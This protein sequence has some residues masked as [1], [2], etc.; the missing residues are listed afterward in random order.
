MKLKID[1]LHLYAVAF[2]NADIN[3]SWLKDI[4]A[5]Y[6]LKTGDIAETVVFDSPAKMVDIINRIINGIAGF[7]NKA[8]ELTD[9]VKQSAH[10]QP[11]DDAPLVVSES[12][13]EG[14]RVAVALL[15]LLRDVAQHAHEK[16]TPLTMNG[17]QLWIV[18]ELI[19]Q[20]II[21]DETEFLS[22]SKTLI[23]A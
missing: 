3:Q 22:F 5:L 21:H 7:E 9:F 12:Y 4:D 10:T 23:A 18:T 2:C 14:L 13:I 17:P 15:T 16:N 11:Q 6:G 1:H 19:E 8:I 20:E